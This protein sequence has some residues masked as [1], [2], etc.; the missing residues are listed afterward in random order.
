MDPFVNLTSYIWP[1]IW[2]IEI[3][4]SCHFLTWYQKLGFQSYLHQ[5][6]RRCA[7]CHCVSLIHALPS[8]CTPDLVTLQPPPPHCRSLDP[9]C[10]CRRLSSSSRSNQRACPPLLAATPAS[11]HPCRACPPLFRPRSP[12]TT[13]TRAPIVWIPRSSI[14]AH[15]EPLLNLFPCACLPSICCL[16]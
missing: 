4:L 11:T 15:L 3:Q 14:R 1:L 16:I 10:S 2:P 5:L 8:S 6:H 7:V 12:V 9:L 13:G